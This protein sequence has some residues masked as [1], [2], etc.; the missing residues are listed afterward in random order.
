MSAHGGRVPLY[1]YDSVRLVRVQLL[2]LCIENYH[3][4]DI[5]SSVVDVLSSQK[6]ACHQLLF[7][8]QCLG[9]DTVLQAKH[10]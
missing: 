6:P 10:I 9:S 7:S 3:E 5:L 8:F 2:I 4:Y 1:T